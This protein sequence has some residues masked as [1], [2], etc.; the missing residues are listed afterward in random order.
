MRTPVNPVT[1]YESE[2]FGFSHAVISRSP[3]LVHCAGQV[4]WDAQGNLVGQGDL[5]VQMRQALANLRAV[6]DAAGASAADIVRLRTYIVGHRPEYLPI[7]VEVL[8]DFYGGVVPAANT[9]IGVQSLALPEFLVEVEA[10]AVL[11]EPTIVSTATQ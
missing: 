8:G 4:A 7:I 9:L 1:M 10:T 6:L 5:A 2:K 11:R 3:S